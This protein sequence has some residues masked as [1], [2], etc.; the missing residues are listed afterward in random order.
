[1]L[2]EPKRPQFVFGTITIVIG[3]MVIALESLSWYNAQEAISL[4]DQSSR[5]GMILRFFSTEGVAVSLI[6]IG[7]Y[8]VCRALRTVRLTASSSSVRS[9]ISDA[10]ASQKDRKVGVVSGALY[11]LV[12]AIVS[13]TLVYQPSVNFLYTYSASSTSW[14]AIACCG[15]P[16]T[17]PALVVY[18]L[19]QAHL[20]LQILPL[21]ALFQ[22]VFPILVGFNLTIVSYSLRSRQTRVTGGWIS[23]VAL[24]AGLFT[25]CPTCAGLFLASTLGGAGATAFALA[26]A[27]YQ[28][29]FVVISIPV[30]LL[31]PILVAESMKKSMYTSCRLPP[32]Q[33]P[34]AGITPR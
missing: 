33:S 22:F 27:P 7:G 16:G 29:L 11:G 8:L 13:S 18:L 3:A 2:A 31:S 23:A 34:T 5:M 32:N 6:I 28:A 10:L 19:P 24:T 25:G 20:A 15:S 30:L 26:L 1:M 17:V 21:G 4:Y 12:Y 9:I 14:N